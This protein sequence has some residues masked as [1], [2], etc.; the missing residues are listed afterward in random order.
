MPPEDTSSCHEEGRRLFYERVGSYF[1]DLKPET[2][3][4]PVPCAVCN[5]PL[6]RGFLIDGL[7]QCVAQ[8]S[9]AERRM[10]Q[11]PK[12]ARVAK[13][14]KKGGMGKVSVYGSFNQQRRAVLIT[15]ERSVVIA[16]I[17]PTRTLP[18]GMRWFATGD[19]TA[20][21]ALYRAAFIDALPTPSL[22]VLFDRRC[23]GPFILTRSSTGVIQ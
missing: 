11:N 5:Q 19:D 14:T 20:F 18:D 1:S 3:P 9:I 17:V 7:A 23:D 8:R 21:G 6:H 10:E 2:F 4:A 12:V 16:N 22:L 13:P 15:P